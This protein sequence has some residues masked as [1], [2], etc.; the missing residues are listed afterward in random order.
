[1]TLKV[2]QVGLIPP[3][4]VRYFKSRIILSDSSFLDAKQPYLVHPFPYN[5]SN[6]HKAPFSGTQDIVS[7]LSK[8]RYLD[9]I[10][11][12]LQN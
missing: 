11:C 12:L 3:T 1:M 10:V 5:I 7:I 8:P 6:W 2:I 9:I 4:Q